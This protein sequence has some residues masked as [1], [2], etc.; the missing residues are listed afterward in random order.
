[1]SAPLR[2]DGIFEARCITT[3]SF[4]TESSPAHLTSRGAAIFPTLNRSSEEYSA[5]SVPVLLALVALVIAGAAA[6]LA[7]AD[8]PM[9]LAVG[10]WIVVHGT[11]P[12][13]EPFAW[14]RPG[15]PYF[16]YSW[17]P[18]IV[19][20]ALI[21]HGGSLALRATTG[22]IFAG[23]FAAMFV[24]AR[25]LGASRATCWLVGI[26]NFL[27]MLSV[28]SFLR[29]QELLFTLVPLAWAVTAVALD[30]PHTSW[31]IVALALLTALAANTHILFPLMAGPLSLCIVRNAS[32]KR[33]AALAL[34]VATGMALSPYALE[35][36]SVF[37]LNFASNALFSA[38]VAE[39]RSGFIAALPI[40]LL[41]C[42]LPFIAWRSLGWRERAVF[43]ALWIAGLV[44]FALHV[45]GL[46]VWWLVIVLVAVIAIERPFAS[47]PSAYRRFPAMLTFAL[48]AVVT[49]SFVVGGAAMTR[50]LSA[51]W[52]A[53]HVTPGITL[54]EP[55][56]MAADPLIEQLNAL[57]VPVRVLT[58]FDLGSY[59]AWR[60]P[61]LS[62]SIDGR[63]IFPDSAALP[64]AMFA[65]GSRAGALG[66]WRSA[67]A[68]LVP[69]DYPVAA[70]LDTAADWTRL[71][72]SNTPSPVGPI[73]L[74]VRS[75][76]YARVCGARCA[77][78]ARPRGTARTERACDR[79]GSCDRNDDGS[80]GS[81]SARISTALDVPL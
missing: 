57:G 35:W 44:A 40:G 69:M 19:F 8:L 56:G 25:A 18:S 46:V 76:W 62:E 15:A 43:G 67:D 30:A 60:G 17:L 65:A 28:T 21:S 16:A 32:I 33:T 24:A 66:P 36:P 5:S 1:M 27:M 26:L 73:G 47:I 14:T 64:D 45:K 68:A 41:L 22:L 80:A 13:I 75:S 4:K 81:S 7:D 37:R 58:V 48:A 42:A 31:P 34:A 59:V 10:R 20:Y 74:W 12:H 63:T 54:S 55:G 2:I 78:H 23:S 38:R 50:S 52:R 29:P 53:E 3:D 11:V 39:Y 79:N 49:A 71:A 61:L 77:A 51:S 9:H 70:V 72:T 6:P